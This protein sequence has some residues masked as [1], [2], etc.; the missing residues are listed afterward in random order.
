M[1]RPEFPR[2]LLVEKLPEGTAEDVEKLLAEFKQPALHNIFIDEPSLGERTRLIRLITMADP[3]AGPLQ[4]QFL[5]KTAG[6]KLALSEVFINEAPAT[7]LEP[8]VEAAA[9][10]FSDYILKLKEYR[11]SELAKKGQAEDGQA[12][13]SDRTSGPVS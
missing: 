7:R 12:E 10:W 5:C 11:D 8:I 2:V 6:R 3:S 9:A 1:N 4:A 13:S